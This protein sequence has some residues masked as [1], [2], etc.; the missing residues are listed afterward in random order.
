MNILTHPPQGKVNLS[1]AIIVSQFILIVV[2]CSGKGVSAPG[3]RLRA[4]QFRQFGMQ[5]GAGIWAGTQHRLWGF[6]LGIARLPD[7][8]AH[9]TCVCVLG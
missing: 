2:T 5:L 7:A 6:T 8:V 4:V 9:H 3:V 1:G